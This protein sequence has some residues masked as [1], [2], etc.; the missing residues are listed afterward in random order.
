MYL[1]KLGV[2]LVRIEISRYKF[3]AELNLQAIHEQSIRLID[4]F[5]QKLTE[6]NLH[7]YLDRY[8]ELSG[9]FYYPVIANVNTDF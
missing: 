5:T 7:V 8:S 2:E 9:M 6:F 1:F 4:N 3:V